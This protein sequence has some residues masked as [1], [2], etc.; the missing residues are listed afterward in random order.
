M[1]S[2]TMISDH[3][4]VE[5]PLLVWGG[6]GTS[7]GVT[8]SVEFTVFE[9]PIPLKRTVFLH[10]NKHSLTPRIVS[11]S[12]TAQS[13]FNRIARSVLQGEQVPFFVAGEGLFARLTFR[14]RRPNNH[15]VGNQRTNGVLKTEKLMPCLLV[16]TWIT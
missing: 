5:S 16:E 11:P 8:R 15:Y 7:D 9:K 12:N 14:L 2:L 4:E 3:H 6:E 1:A 13:N 10:K